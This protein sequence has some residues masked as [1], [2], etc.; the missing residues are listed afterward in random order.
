ML[1]SLYSQKNHI[2]FQKELFL[3]KNH[4]HNNKIYRDIPR[5]LGMAMG[6]F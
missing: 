4:S 3:Y 2:K 1:L 5:I 6:R